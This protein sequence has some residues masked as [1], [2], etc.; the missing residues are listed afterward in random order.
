MRSYTA[1]ELR[2]SMSRKPAHTLSCDD[3]V[4]SD[5]GRQQGLWTCTPFVAEKPR[6]EQYDCGSAVR[7]HVGSTRGSI[8]CWLQKK[9][10][11]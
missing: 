7:L 4:V 10:G 1:H 11:M 8:L 2:T 5:A 6:S 9:L 3:A